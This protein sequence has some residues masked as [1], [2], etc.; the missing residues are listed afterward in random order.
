[1]YETQRP[2]HTLKQQYYLSFFGGPKSGPAVSITEDTLK[3]WI[4]I[5]FF[6]VLKPKYPSL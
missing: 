1:M 6:V 3:W 5:L 4:F 2:P